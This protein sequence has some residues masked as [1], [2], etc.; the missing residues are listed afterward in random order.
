MIILKKSCTFYPKSITYLNK[1][2]RAYL[3]LGI[4]FSFFAAS[5]L[6][7]QGIWRQLG[8]DIDGEASGDNTGHSV[9]ISADGQRVAIGAPANDDNGDLAGQVQIYELKGSSWMQLGGDIHGEAAGDFSGNSVSLS[10]DGKRVAIGAPAFLSGQA[11]YVQVYEYNGH[12]WIQLGANIDGAASGDQN[13][14]AVSL[15]ADGQRVAIGAPTHKDENGNATGQVRVYQYNGKHWSQIGANM[16]GEA[17]DDNSGWS[18]SLSANGQRVAI[19][20]PGSSNRPST[21]QVQVYEYNGSNWVQLGSDIEGKEEREQFGLSISLS[22][23]GNRVAIGAP[24]S[25]ANGFQTGRVEVYEYNGSNWV[26]IGAEIRGKTS[27]EESGTSVSLSADGQQLA[28]GVPKTEQTKDGNGRG[29]VRLYEYNGNTWMPLGA[30]ID[31]EALGNNSGTSVSLS[32]DGSRVAIGAPLNAANRQAG[33]VRVYEF[34]AD[35]RA[36]AITR[37]ILVNTEANIIGANRDLR[38]LS[39]QDEIDLARYQDFGLNIRAEAQGNVGSVVFTG[40]GFSPNPKIENLA[41]YALGGDANGNFNNI[42]NQFQAGETLTI[43]ATPYEHANGQG[44]AGEAFTSVVRIVN[45]SENPAPRLFL[46]NANSNQDI[47]ELSAQDEINLSAFED[48]GLNIRA[49]APGEVESIVFTGN[50][51]SP[52]PKIENLAPYALG[53]DANGNFNNI[54]N[55]FQAGDILTITARPYTQNNGQGVAGNAATFQIRI[56]DESHTEFPRLALINTTNQQ[57]IGPL[58][59]ATISASDLDKRGVVLQTQPAHTNLGLIRFQLN[60]EF[61]QAEGLAPYSLAG[62]ANQSGEIFP[63]TQEPKVIDL[64]NLS[65]QNTLQAL[66]EGINLTVSF[67]ITG[68]SPAKLKITGT[69]QPLPRTTKARVYP[70]PLEGR[71]IFVS[72]LEPVFGEVRYT[73]WDQEGHEV[74]RGSQVLMSDQ[75]A[76]EIKLPPR[77]EAKQGTF[78]LQVEGANFPPELHRL[79]KH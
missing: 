15:S 2:L 5:N 57:L 26:Q 46:V 69:D 58:Q 9:S 63:L 4:V 41:P 6:P 25:S 59:Q 65:G 40:N 61:A 75:Q 13:G 42:K 44:R 23:D 54:K 20:A 37:L 60:G 47:R 48:I 76:L 39:A 19:G 78:Y 79:L 17:T 67:S 45:T 22:S 49:E 43:T 50:G 34:D 52:N 10:A 51:F 62:D 32:A 8:Q 36:F 16:D 12:A 68:A 64:L 70:V 21:N 30:F 29:Q 55:Q 53:G 18:V 27:R 71:S 66:G 38:E 31:G 35:P 33:H 1:L 56:K 7:A 11:G 73:I 74:S 3:W 28:I 77:W 24:F 72:F 14:W